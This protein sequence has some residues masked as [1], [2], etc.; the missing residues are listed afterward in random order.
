M[1]VDLRLLRHAR[2]LAEEGNFARAARSLHLSQ[3]ALTRSIQVLEQRVGFALFERGPGRVEPT[4]LGR[5]F[6]EHAR[7]VLAGADVLEREVAQM[8]GA[9]SGALMLGAGTYIS[10]AVVEPALVRFV[11]NN[12]D[13][14]LEVVNDSGSELLGRLRT[15]RVHLCVG[16]AP[17]GEELAGMHAT[18]L[19]ARR[20]WLFV[21]AGH[22]WAQRAAVPMDEAARRPLIGPTRMPPVMVDMLLK[23]GP[24][25]RTV[26]DFACES[27]DMMV[28]VALGTDHLLLVGLAMIE[29]AVASGLLVPLRLDHPTP[30]QPFAIVRRVGRS[31][32][33]PVERLIDAI[34]IADLENAARER[35][36]IERIVA[37][38]G[39]RLPAPEAP[40]SPDATP[41]EPSAASAAQPSEQPIRERSAQ[42][43]AQRPA[44]SAATRPDAP[45]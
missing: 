27:V 5:L 21:R 19:H 11:A 33:G 43:S 41:S 42:P 2:A 36:A 26:P 39:P 18:P 25:R 34:L 3:P 10:R 24:G 37:A 28:R 40:P 15:G 45:R 30:P 9:A 4:D 23:A 29:D 7:P 8:R 16:S 14:A 20:G 6:L 31:L 32:P 1:D 13:V 38:G 12:P 35:A 44:G 17:V 22:P